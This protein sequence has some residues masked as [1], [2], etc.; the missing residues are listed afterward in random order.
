MYNILQTKREFIESLISALEQTSQVIP[1]G[2]LQM[3]PK[4]RNYGLIS[5]DKNRLLGKGNQDTEVYRG[6]F[7]DM[8]VAVKVIKSN[9]GYARKEVDALQKLDRHKNVVRYY[10]S[11]IHQ[12]KIYIAFELCL[13][14]LQDE[15]TLKLLSIDTVKIVSGCIKGVRFLHQEGIIHRDFKPTNILVNKYKRIKITDFGFSKQLNPGMSVASMS[16]NYGTFDWMAPEIINFIEM[17]D[18]TKKF[19]SFLSFM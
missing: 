2:I 12:N 9:V 6:T 18:I 1:L 17:P 8:D 11:E 19:V 14:N 5:I 3:K 13:H 7:N 16:G 4:F 10:F 15:I